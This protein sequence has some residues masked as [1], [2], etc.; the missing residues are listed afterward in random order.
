[1]MLRSVV[2]FVSLCVALPAQ[3]ADDIRVGSWNIEFL[4]AY[5]KY[6]RDTPPRGEEAVQ[7]I[8]KKITELGFSVLGV[9]EICGEDVATHAELTH[10]KYTQQVQLK[11][12]I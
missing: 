11:F 4:G 2:L 1:M 8:G 5:P 7:A 9:Q 10:K 3:V 6:R 12:N